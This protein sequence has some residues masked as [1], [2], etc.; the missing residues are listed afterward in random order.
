MNHLVSCDVELALNIINENSRGLIVKA[1]R[2]SAGYSNSRYL[3]YWGQYNTSKS[4]NTSLGVCWLGVPP[5]NYNLRGLGQFTPIFIPTSVYATELHPSHY[6]TLFEKIY[7]QFLKR[8]VYNFL[9]EE[10]PFNAY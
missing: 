6:F 2:V 8:F 4:E 7:I 3:C 5:N 9:N 10:F 1:E